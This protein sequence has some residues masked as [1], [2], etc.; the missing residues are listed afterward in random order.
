MAVVLS[1]DNVA[2]V[3]RLSVIAASVTALVALTACGSSHQAGSSVVRVFDPTGRVGTEV[4]LAG[5]DRRDIGVLPTIEPGRNTPKGILVHRAAVLWLPFTKSGEATFCRL[6][7]ALAQRGAATHDHHE[8]YAVEIDGHVYQSSGMYTVNYAGG[9]ADYCAPPHGVYVK[10]GHTTASQLTHRLRVA[11]ILD[12]RALTPG[13]SSTAGGQRTLSESAVKAA[14]A[15][16]GFR[17]RYPGLWEEGGLPR[18]PHALPLS[19]VENGGVKF[20]NGGV[21][22]TP[23]GPYFEVVVFRS[24][25]SARSAFTPRVLLY[26][27]YLRQPWAQ[28]SNVDLVATLSIGP[29]K[30]GGVVWQRAL[31]VLNTFS[32]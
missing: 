18:T 10:A 19:Y 17:L 21:K 13:T 9:T 12:L 22:I 28:S 14:F 27:K 26:L 24:A 29:N 20:N 23:G 11:G 6:V 1:D 31:H 2:L 32:R 16:H 25:A 15:R 4:T 7:G 8:Q 3:R 30:I 5:V